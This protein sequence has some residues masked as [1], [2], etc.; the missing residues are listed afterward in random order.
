MLPKAVFYSVAISKQLNTAP[1]RFQLAYYMH[2]TA[3]A[4]V[5]KFMVSVHELFKIPCGR[6]VIF[7]L[8]EHTGVL[9][10]AV[11]ESLGQIPVYKSTREQHSSTTMI[12]QA[13]IR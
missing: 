7:N 12:D 13:K 1:I 9:F 3:M 10:A 8:I 6:V 2:G 5:I 11:L 4:I